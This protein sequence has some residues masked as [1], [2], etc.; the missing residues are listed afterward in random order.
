MKV[1]EVLLAPGAGQVAGLVSLSTWDGSGGV[2]CLSTASTGLLPAAPT[3]NLHVQEA[4]RCCPS[5][6][7]VFWP[8][9]TH[10]CETLVGLFSRG[11]AQMSFSLLEQRRAV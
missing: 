6:L 4:P 8:P 10:G 5:L 2:Q 9:F 1:S 3:T 7:P 11:K